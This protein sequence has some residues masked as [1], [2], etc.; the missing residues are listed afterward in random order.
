MAL[1][2][3]KPTRADIILIVSVLFI[4]L[5]AI[6]IL[7]VFGADNARGFEI[8]VDGRLH[9]SYSFSDLK[10]GDTIEIK[11]QYGYNKFLYEKQSIRCIES[12][13]NDRLEINAGA[14]GKT[15]QV[16]VCL[17]H[18]LTVNIVGKDKIDAVAY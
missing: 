8:K 6:A 16:L 15:N 4:S 17:P 12:D 13:C 1:P 11:T 5:F 2:V 14:I 7:F 3:N 18:R 9:S 10:D